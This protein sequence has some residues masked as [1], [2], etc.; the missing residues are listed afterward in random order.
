M[1]TRSAR[2]E[3]TRRRL[4][5]LTGAGAVAA[6]LGGAM[7][8]TA[9]AASATVGCAGPGG[10]AAGLRAAI[11][12]SN[13]TPGADT[14]DLAAG[15]TYVLTNEANPGNGLPVVTGT[16]VIHG[17]GAT[18]RR[19]SESAFRIL[20]VATGAD[21]TLDQITVSG[22]SISS[23]GGPTAFGGGI[24]NSGRLTV[25]D[26]TISDNAV[27]G[28]GSSAGGGGIANNGTVS[29]HATVLRNNTATATGSGLQI[30]AAVGGAVLNRT[31]ATMT[32]DD[33]SVVANSAISTGSSQLFFIASAGGIGNS[34]TLTVNRTDVNGNRAVADGA[35]G[36]AGGGGISIAD[37][38]VTI[39]DSTIAGNAA[40]ARGAGAEAHGGGVENN[41]QTKLTD[42]EVKGNLATGPVAQ[43]GGLYNGRRLILI[44]SRVVANVAAG[45]SGSG[46][47]GGIFTD[48]GHV[49]LKATLVS[50]NQPDDCQPVI[51][52]C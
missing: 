48:A 14:I 12:H 7:A 52:G 49:T 5:T 31:G 1:A 16:L 3:R 8:G 30:F 2:R 11:T 10:G 32:I 26:S 25:V 23:S 45:T 9:Y 40:T 47:G 29:L 27:S 35:N 34:G 51:A 33:S 28:T 24:L 46:Q 17:H 37:G 43:G 22:G 50:A 19:S 18:V 41:G 15:C 38:V 13:N 44:R 42:T 21:L 4:H 6:V 36:R 20:E 39:A